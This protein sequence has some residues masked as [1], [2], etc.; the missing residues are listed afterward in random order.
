M[1]AVMMMMSALIA[2]SLVTRMIICIRE[3]DKESDNGINSVPG[4]D[5]KSDRSQDAL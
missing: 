2:L 4:R 3:Y 5:I 1:M